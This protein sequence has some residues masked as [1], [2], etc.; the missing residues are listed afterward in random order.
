MSSPCSCCKKL[1]ES[2]LV[3]E[4]HLHLNVV[5]QSAGSKIYRCSLCDTMFEFTVQDIYL[6]DVSTVKACADD[7]FHFY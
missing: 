6:L 3:T 2:A 7:H 1:I 5:R 4:P